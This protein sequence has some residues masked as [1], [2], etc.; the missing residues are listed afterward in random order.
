MTILT[1]DKGPFLSKEVVNHC[2]HIRNTQ[3]NTGVSH[4]EIHAETQDTEK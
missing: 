2:Y 4:T 1:C 3:S